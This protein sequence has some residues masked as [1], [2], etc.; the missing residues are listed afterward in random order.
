MRKNFFT[1]M[2]TEHWDRL[3]REAA[4]SPLET[5]KTHLDVDSVQPA[6]EENLL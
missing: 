2:V 1:L 4:G 6:L 3:P 5:F